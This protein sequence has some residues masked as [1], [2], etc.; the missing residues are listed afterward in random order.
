MQQEGNI[1]SEEVPQEGTEVTSDA[2]DAAKAEARKNEAEHEGPERVD[3][4]LFIRKM[5]QEAGLPLNVTERAYEAFLATLLGEVRAGRR[6]NLTGF[7]SFF[8]KQRKGHPVHFGHQAGA[9]IEDYQVLKFQASRQSSGFLQRDP[10][11]VVGARVPGTRKVV[12]RKLGEDDASAS[13][14]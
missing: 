1:V 13:E 8:W 6:V 9:R 11:E 12:S 4:R 7:G 3:K 5:A 14:G 10:N 2:T